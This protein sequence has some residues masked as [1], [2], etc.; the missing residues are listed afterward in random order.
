VNFD[1]NVKKNLKF[2]P[3]YTTFYRISMI[4]LRLGLKNT[5]EIIGG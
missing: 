2:K 5:N 3:T 4:S 1:Q